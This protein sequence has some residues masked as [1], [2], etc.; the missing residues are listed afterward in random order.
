MNLRKS[1]S[2]FISI[3]VL[4]SISLPGG[5]TAFATSASSESSAP[6]RAFLE[7]EPV[8]D[9]NI[10]LDGDGFAPGSGG[11]VAL[12]EH[13]NFYLGGSS[14]VSWGNPVSSHKG[15]YD[16]FVAKVTS[17][18]NL[19]WN[20]FIGG[21]K[22]DSLCDI[23]IDDSGNIYVAGHSPESWG[24][25]VRSFSGGMDGFVA[26]LDPSGELIWNTFLGGSEYD[27]ALSLFLDDAGNIFV[28]G[29]ASATW[30]NPVR[31]YSGNSDG[32]V[33]QLTPT[34]D[35]VWNTFLGN[36]S[37][38]DAN[39]IIL[40]S[41][42]EIFISGISQDSWGTPVELPIDGMS[43][44]GFVAKL[45]STGQ[46]IWNT[47]VGGN[48]S[49]SQGLAIADNGD[50]YV[51]G[52]G[53]ESWG[54]PI[55]PLHGVYDV[56][57]VKLDGAGTRIWNT[58]VG[59]SGT[60]GA[61]EILLDKNGDLYITGISNKSWGTP[62]R[63]YIQDIDAFAAK[64]DSDGALVWNTFLGGPGKDY[65]TGLVMDN[66]GNTYLSGNST[67]LWGEG[68]RTT[69]KA[70]TGLFEENP[71]TISADSYERADKDVAE[72]AL[73]ASANNNG[74]QIFISDINYIENAT[75]V[76]LLQD[77]SFETFTPNLYWEESS[78]H[79]YTPLC[80]LAVCGN[81]NGTAGPHKGSVW[82][83]FGGIGDGYNE[84]ASL[85]QFVLIPSGYEKLNLQ[86][87]L[88]IGA[89]VTG[90]GID[91]IFS[92]K[93]D[94]VTIFSANATQQ[95]S[96][97]Q[98]TP[99][100]IDITA[101]ADG[102]PHTITFFS[103]TTY[104]LVSFNLDDVAITSATFVDTPIEHWAW[105]YV[106]RLYNAGITGGC[107]NAIYCPDKTVTRAQMAVF[108][109]KG[110]RGP[111]FTPSPAT[112]TRFNDVPASHWAAAWV[113]QLAADGITGG[114]GAGNYCPE[115]PVTRAQMAV[116][117]LK[118]K[119]GS[120]YSPPAV[121]E[122][123]GFGDVAADYWAAAW[124]KQLAAEGITGG[125]GAGNYCPEQPVTRA[126]MAVFLV[127]TFNLP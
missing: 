76:N 48:D 75:K 41:A 16:G 69:A 91:D 80:T 119:Y 56:F 81:G 46:L 83:W 94:D 105:S 113:E 125:C 67:I 51:I 20:T 97:A 85:S 96:Y 104:Q 45:S 108:L 26:K 115:N 19:V 109:E 2:M 14:S 42:G 27:A 1:F 79:F 43:I 23:F 55:E 118:S 60:D 32:F 30:G 33:A 39:T 68:K 87:Y 123:T 17:S 110:T 61:S 63:S 50:L 47:F 86:F 64:M 49:S 12:D 122:S 70:M 24:N 9:L 54:D 99:I 28:T 98:Y 65:A 95:N 38:D 21:S 74:D 66:I 37:L 116:F 25:P 88:W 62:S 31:G 36:V 10:F 117:L 73:G 127:R 93:I 52:T 124:I 126:Q 72:K 58:F 114:C 22:F 18:G 34:G 53:Y 84:T 78:T 100:N 13:G 102:Q 5:Q 92:V 121:D 71:I 40:N 11:V 7:A 15:D 90:S 82:S 8:Q 3:L 111:G 6:S 106:E 35:L 29:F 4:L 89:A 107:G 44:N 103:Q 59:G 101:F 112:G 77:P 120:S 57:V